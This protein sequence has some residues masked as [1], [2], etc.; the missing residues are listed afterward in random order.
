MLFL[1]GSKVAWPTPKDT[2]EGLPAK[3][4]EYLDTKNQAILRDQAGLHV[5]KLLLQNPC[6]FPYVTPKWWKALHKALN[7]RETLEALSKAP[8]SKYDRDS[9]TGLGILQVLVMKKI[10]GEIGGDRPPLLAKIADCPEAKAAIA[11]FLL[12]P[13][14]KKEIMNELRGLLAS[15]LAYLTPTTVWFLDDKKLM[16][17][18][19]Q[20]HNRLK[21]TFCIHDRFE[22]EPGSL[23]NVTDML[24]SPKTLLDA[25]V[26]AVI[27]TM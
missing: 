11:E 15:N 23:I 19:S 27:R 6:N 17:M 18:K 12:Q 10:P 21:V 1:G 4:D 9:R 7:A 22:D 20:Q 26:K 5:K 24:K 2:T 25:F 13:F 8:V 14:E 3:F 16:G